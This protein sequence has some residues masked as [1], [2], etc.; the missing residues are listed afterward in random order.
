MK[1]IITSQFKQ[2]GLRSSVY[3]GLVGFFSDILSPIAPFSSYLFFISAF[4]VVFILI[5]MVVKS[6]LQEKMAPALIVSITLFIVSGLFFV[7]QVY[8]EK[9]SKEYGVLASQIPA[10]KTYQSFLRLIQEDVSEII[11][12]TE[13]ID[14]ETTLTE[15]V[16]I[17]TE[18]NTEVTKKVGTAID[19]YEL[20]I[21]YSQC[22]N[23]SYRHECF[24][25]Y[26]F[27][28]DR[29]NRHAGYFRDN[30]IW[31]GLL[32]QND[33][34]SHETY[35][36][37][38]KAVINC[39]K[40]LEGWYHCPDGQKLKPL[41]DGY[42][43]VNGKGQGKF[44]IHFAG[45]NVFEGNYENDARNGY[46]K[47]TWSNGDVYEGSYENDAR[48]GYG[49]YTW[50]NGDVYEGNYENDARNGYGTKTWSNGDVYEGSWKNDVQNGHGSKT[51][52]NGIVY[53]GNFE[54]GDQKGY[55]NKTWWYENGQMRYEHN[56]KD[57]KKDGKS[58]RWY[59]NGQMR[60][61]H[62]FKDGK[63][64]GK[65][66]WWHENGQIKLEENYKDGK[67]D[68][69]ETYWYENGQRQS[70]SNYKDG[71]CISGDC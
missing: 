12:S 65:F 17:N 56:F 10:F 27:G 49:K 45:G 47:Y 30:L 3:M 50:S 55:G 53:E 38:K 66:I 22:Q 21:K 7:L 6:T 15:Q 64:D 20:S 23:S 67:L 52:S 35:E 36:G 25:D 16:E 68:G 70:E 43:D 14:K 37:V 60:Y 2:I 26:S 13:N 71:K 34:L 61:E 1:T 46:G 41:E 58:T 4:M 40:G 42:I 39:H 63:K 28:K 57:G 59:E 62:N 5:V 24:D 29:I 8:I 18:E 54:N 11:K 48:N 19:L 31:E 44:I 51:W 69:K 33:V 9:D 32:W